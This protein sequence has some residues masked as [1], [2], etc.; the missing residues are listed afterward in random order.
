LKKYCCVILVA[1]ILTVFGC[2]TKVKDIKQSTIEAKIT[3]YGLYKAEGLDNKMRHPSEEVYLSEYYV[4][5]IEKTT[6]VI[7]LKK[8]TAFGF[9]WSANGFNMNE[10]QVIIYRIEH[11]PMILPSGVTSTISNLSGIL[12]TEDGRF[13]DT[14]CYSF[15][16]DF[17]MVP[18]KWTVS[19]IHN[20]KVLVSKTFTIQAVNP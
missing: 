10:K 8:E 20:D 18:G 14:F 4:L 13:E 9:T 17:E 11:P 5:S 19:A 15:E 7:P 3:N 6:D 12:T 1:I 2:A 16:E